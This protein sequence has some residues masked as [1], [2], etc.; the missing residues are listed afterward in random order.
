MLDPKDCCGNNPDAVK[1]AARK[2]R[3]GSPELV[4]AWLAADERRR[5]AQTQADA[6][7]PSRARS[8]GRSAR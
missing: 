8:A 2:K 3:V 1:D 4:D 5:A 7:A 6:L